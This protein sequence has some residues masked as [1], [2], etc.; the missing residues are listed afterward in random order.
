M[1]ATVAKLASSEAA[2]SGNPSPTA[3]ASQAGLAFSLPIFEGG[4]LSADYRGARGD[5]DAAV[6]A[7]DIAGYRD[8]PPGLRLWAGPTVEKSDLAALLPWLDWALSEIA[9]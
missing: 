8:A 3:T 2:V 9:D 7:Y 4:R 6:A 5:Y 1:V